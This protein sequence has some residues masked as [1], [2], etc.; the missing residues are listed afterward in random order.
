ME[1]GDN[2]DFRFE[3]SG[4]GVCFENISGSCGHNQQPG[5]GKSTHVQVDNVVNRRHHNNDNLQAIT[6]ITT[7]TTTHSTTT[8]RRAT[9]N[10]PWRSAAKELAVLSNPRAT[11]AKTEFGDRR[12]QLRPVKAPAEEGCL[13]PSFLNVAPGGST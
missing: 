13:E 9:F 6:T 10:V 11:D 7:T 5:V 12:A 4:S 3:G 2:D 8:A 1:N